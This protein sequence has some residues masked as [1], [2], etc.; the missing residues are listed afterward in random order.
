MMNMERLLTVWT[1]DVNQQN[2]HRYQLFSEYRLFE[3][4]QQW[5]YG[6]SSST[7]LVTEL[8]QAVAVYVGFK[9]CTNLYSIHFIKV[10]ASRRHCNCEYSSWTHLQQHY[11]LF[12]KSLKY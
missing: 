5:V 12:P 1:G 9:I 10:E 2:I 7:D 4:L 8:R 3:D 6:N 11:I